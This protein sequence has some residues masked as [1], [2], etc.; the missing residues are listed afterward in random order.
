ML[1]GDDKEKKHLY[2]FA[3][4]I[5]PSLPTPSAFH[6]GLIESLSVELTGMTG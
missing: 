6:F 3:K 1:R 2:T 4:V 5:P